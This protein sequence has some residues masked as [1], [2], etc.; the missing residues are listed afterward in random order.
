MKPPSGVVRFEDLHAYMICSQMRPDEIKQLLAFSGAKHYDHEVA[1]RGFISNSGAKFTLVDASDTPII[2]G[3]YWPISVPG[4][5]QSWMAGSEEGWKFHWRSITK[6]SRWLMDELFRTGARRLQ[7]NGLADRV[8]AR[9]WYEKG[10]GLKYEGTWRGFGANGEDVACYG[11]TREDYYGQ[12]QQ[13]RSGPG[14]AG[15]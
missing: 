2:V 8:Q 10:L 5:W 4:V 13:R 3:G 14:S 9:E 1:A 6:A 11:L 15:S 7:T 12:Q